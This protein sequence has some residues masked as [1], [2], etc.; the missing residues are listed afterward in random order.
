M[1]WKPTPSPYRVS[2]DGDFTLSRAPSAPPEPA[3]SKKASKAALRD[4]VEAIDSLQE[5]LYAVAHDF[6]GR[7]DEAVRASAAH[8][9]L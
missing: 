5:R 6:D 3:P 8:R 7:S 9:P 1:D 2:F 4:H